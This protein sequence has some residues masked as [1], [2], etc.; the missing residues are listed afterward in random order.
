[1]SR[2]SGFR[3]GLVRRSKAGERRLESTFFMINV[4]FLLLLFF[5]VAGKLN[6]DVTVVPPQAAPGGA[7]VAAA[8]RVS[9]EADGT[10]RLNGA[11]M[12]LDALG[13][14]LDAAAPIASLAIAADRDADA[15]LVARLLA[16]A[17]AHVTGRTTLV[18]MPRGAGGAAGG[19]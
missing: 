8:L 9:I 6:V 1:V 4:I 19:G 10:L 2:R 12:P 15:V 7:D 17:A 18:T 13:K 3:D 14:A 5:V 16:A 11:A